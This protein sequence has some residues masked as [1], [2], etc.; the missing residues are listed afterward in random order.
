MGTSRSIRRGL[1]SS[2]AGLLLIANYKTKQR[3]GGVTKPKQI[4]NFRF[5]LHSKTMEHGAYETVL[6]TLYINER[7]FETSFNVDQSRSPYMLDRYDKAWAD[8]YTKA[9]QEGY[10]P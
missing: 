2:P 5:L 7:Y 4:R 6:L 8:L 9:R 10:L 1:G 3:S